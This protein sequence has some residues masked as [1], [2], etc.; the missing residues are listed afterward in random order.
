MSK[1]KLIYSTSTHPCF[2]QGIIKALCEPYFDIEVYDPAVRYS[3]KNTV[4]LQTHVGVLQANPWHTHLEEQGF[5]VIVDHLWDSDVDTP[6]QVIDNA[7]ILR[8]G[9]WLWYRE[10]LHYQSLGYNQY[11]PQP[12]YQYS[13]FMPINKARPHK[14]LVIERLHS[15]LHRALYS[16]AERGR[17]L[18]DD[19]DYAQQGYWLYYFNSA[20]YNTTCFSVVVESWMRSDTWFRNPSLPNYKTEISEK[21]FKP[22]AYSHPF[23]IFGSVDTL[24]YLKSQGFE[25]YDNLWNES[26]DSIANDDERHRTVA[27]TV[28]DAVNE[29]P[30]N[31][32]TVDS[33]TQ[34]KLTHNRNRFFDTE[35]VKKRFT[36]E[37]IMD[38]M[39]Y[40]NQ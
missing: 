19:F 8:N 39:N 11:Q 10:S 29:Y 3:P 27:N 12:N 13:F 2:C 37:I 6:S 22:M 28:I 36:D 14:D 24:K 30:H 18:P 17:Y 33:L 9:N 5:S 32:W 34:K 31:Q 16:Y 35:L 25:T 21:S 23:I 7:L 26:Y 4:I 1:V 20:W 15:V 38:V 40:I